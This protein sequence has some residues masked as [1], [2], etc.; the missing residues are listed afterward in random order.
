MLRVIQGTIDLRGQFGS[1][2]ATIYPLGRRRNDE[3]RVNGTAR[4][5]IGAFVRVVAH[6]VSVFSTGESKEEGV[7]QRNRQ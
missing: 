4:F 1:Q 3:V 5:P 6:R 2:R 7:E